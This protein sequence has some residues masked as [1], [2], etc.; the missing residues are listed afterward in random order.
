MRLGTGIDRARGFGR[1]L[2]IAALMG[3]TCAAA[4]MTA[5]PRSASA[6]TS[7]Q[8]AFAIPAGPLSGALAA[9][10]RQAGVQVA[11]LPETATGK[12]TSGVT[13]AIS[14]GEALSRLLAGTGLSYRFTG[15]NTVTIT[16]QVSAAH[17]STDADGALVL[18]TIDV[19]A[20]AGAGANAP[21]ETAG[22]SAHISAEQMERFPLSSTGDLFRSTPGV[23]ATANRAGTKLDVNIRGL[24]G[25][26]RVGI[27]LD[28]AMQSLSTYRGYQ[29]AG[30]RV[31]VDPELIGGIDITKGPG[32]GSQAPGAI[33]GT[34][35]MRT[36]NADD[37]LISGREFG[38]R[39]RLST[40]GNRIDPVS[41][42]R[43]APMVRRCPRV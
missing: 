1:R 40:V 31:Y 3:S 26:N 33:G 30:S 16:D 4:V 32:D 13:G 38:T 8:T 39:I 18:D 9:F 41:G 10:G 35:A 15:A 27:T 14:H 34:V 7:Q 11:Y 25:M 43:P 42:N 28:G 17:G 12:R 2:L 23:M 21:Y 37:I 22:S 24:Q 19:S 6:Q 36:L 29:G 20:G 5:M